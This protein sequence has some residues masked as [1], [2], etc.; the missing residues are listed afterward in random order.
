MVE[1][2]HKASGRLAMQ[3]DIILNP[4]LLRNKAKEF[5]ARAKK[6]ADP[7]VKSALLDQARVL[8][9]QALAVSRETLV[10]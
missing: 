5:Q 10:E 6:A 1:E 2:T 7:R 8:V 9:R 4:D 3:T